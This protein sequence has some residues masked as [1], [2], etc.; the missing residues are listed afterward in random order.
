[1]TGGGRGGG[2]RTAAAAREGV[3][4]LGAETPSGRRLDEMTRFF[5]LVSR[6]MAEIAEHWH[7]VFSA[8]RGDD[9]TPEAGAA[10]APPGADPG[11]GAR[12]GAAERLPSD[13]RP[14]VAPQGGNRT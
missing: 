4:A 14:D 13:R 8:R 10:A 6:D 11:R 2:P 3:E 5:E 7:A 1:M 12:P 9:G